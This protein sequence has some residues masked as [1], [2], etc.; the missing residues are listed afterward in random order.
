MAKYDVDEVKLRQLEEYID[1]IEQKEGALIGVLYKAQEIFGYLPKDVQLFIARKLGIFAAKVY[2]VA[3]FY[4]YFT[5]EP[6]GKHVINVC[7]GTACFVKGADKILEEI[8]KELDIK[9]GNMSKDGLFTVDTLRCVGACGLA[10]VV[11][12]DGKV[13]GR[14]KVEEV[15]GILD[16]YRE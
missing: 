8:K 15:K 11:M 4:S 9:D 1:S 14:V 7:M 16:E 13:Y 2:G 5:M 3:T 10:P 6:R 12:V